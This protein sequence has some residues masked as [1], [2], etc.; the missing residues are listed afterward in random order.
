[1]NDIITVDFVR[2]HGRTLG[3]AQGTAPLPVRRAFAQLQS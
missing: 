1:M 2:E 3:F